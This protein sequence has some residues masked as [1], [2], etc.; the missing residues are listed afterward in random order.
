MRKLK[1]ALTP[2]SVRALGKSKNFVSTSNEIGLTA[3]LDPPPKKKKTV[4]CLGKMIGQ[5]TTSKVRLEEKS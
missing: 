5:I 1:N 4:A 2:L 3:K